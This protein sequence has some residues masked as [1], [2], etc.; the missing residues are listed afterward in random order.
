M[1]TYLSAMT[2]TSATNGSGPV[3]RDGLSLAVQSNGTEN[4]DRA[5]WAAARVTC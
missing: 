3:E 2:W 5:E 4:Y 1:T